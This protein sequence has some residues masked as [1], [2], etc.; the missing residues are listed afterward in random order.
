MTDLQ[1]IVDNL[2]PASEPRPYSFAAGDVRL[3]S[4]LSLEEVVEEARK[5]VIDRGRQSV[6]RCTSV[7][8]TWLWLI[9]DVDESS[10]R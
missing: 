3:S 7:G 8:L 2:T 6:R 10:A 4:D 5:R 9:Q 1:I